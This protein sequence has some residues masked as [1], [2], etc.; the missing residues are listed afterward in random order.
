MQMHFDMLNRSRLTVN[1]KVYMY[2]VH[3]SVDNAVV[4][5]NLREYRHS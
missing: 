3:V 2:I 1:R 5:S 4:L